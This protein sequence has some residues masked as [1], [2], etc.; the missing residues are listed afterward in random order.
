MSVSEAARNAALAFDIPGTLLSIER[1]GTGHI[2]D[3]YCA[4]F[5]V[6]GTV[7]RFLVQRINHR[8][9][10]EPQLL[11]ENIHRATTHLAAQ[12]SDDPDRDRRV[13]TL[14]PDRDGRLCH[15]DGEGEFWRV[16]RFIEK[17]HTYDT[18]QSPA[19]AF[20]VARAFGQFQRML[21]TLP[22]P[23]LNE[24]IPDFHNTPK[25]LEAFLRAVEADPRNRASEAR[26]EIDYALEHQAL[27]GIL[28]D[29]GLPERTI[30]ADTK[31]N[32]VLLD[33]ATGEGLC[34]IDL[35]TV[36]P[37]LSLYDFG[38]MV[39][40]ATSPAA[41]DERDL[42]KVAMQMPMFEALVR[43]YMASTA[44]FLSAQEKTLLVAAGKLITYEQCL[45]FLTDFLLG[46]PYYK[47]ARE[48][49]NLDRCRTQIKLLESIAG[50]EDEMQRFVENSAASLNSAP[51]D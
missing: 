7:A 10:K 19:Q 28:M 47:I 11:V 6:A 46:D 43:G 27:A 22:P 2:N 50:Q 8:I 33:D 48:A 4:A 15:V 39:R 40:T 5:D 30:H 31:I 21:V 3:S 1:Y 12:L 20:Q 49:H 45:R 29:A 44:D 16:Y 42:S 41:E 34:V 51:A 25:R 36:M 13:L 35:D 14:L 9:F 18:I 37:G 32:N 23:R 38:D 24:T 26:R 17:A